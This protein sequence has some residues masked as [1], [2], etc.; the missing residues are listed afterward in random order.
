MIGIFFVGEIKATNRILTH[1]THYWQLSHVISELKYRMCTT[2]CCH[3]KS[4]YGTVLFHNSKHY[5]LLQYRNILMENNFCVVNSALHNGLLLV[6][7]YH[8]P[9]EPPVL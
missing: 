4:T 5:K 8:K 6:Y 2:G 9:I 3:V 1:N 7:R